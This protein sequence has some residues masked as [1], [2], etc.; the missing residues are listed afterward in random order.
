MTTP[1]APPTFIWGLKRSGIHLVVSWLYA[2]RGGAER[3]DLEASD[4]HPQLRDGFRDADAGVGLYNNCGGFSSRQFSLGDVGVG[5]FERA[6]G[7]HTAAIFGI[8][9]C[10][11]RW[12][13]PATEVAGSVHVLVLR[14]PL[15]NL[16]SR[17][18][19]A[20]A[21]PEVF[22]VDAAYIDL[23]EAYCAEYLRRTRHLPAA[24]LVGFNRFVVD[25]GYRDSLAAALGVENRDEIGEVS[26]YGG[27]SSFAEEAP[28]PDQ[29]M[30]RFRQHPIP[31]DLLDLLL[32]RSA[33]Q[34]VCATTFGYDLAALVAEA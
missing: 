22:R 31:R 2:N 1:V 9:D 16:A 21:R 28:Q 19:G 29:L 3:H 33:V 6:A 27:G 12:A 17:L 23:L 5:D 15:N 14:D 34:E 8:E 26:P 18:A 13:T 30:S 32:A 11:L 7:R 25:R 10:A 20:R 4:L 24:V